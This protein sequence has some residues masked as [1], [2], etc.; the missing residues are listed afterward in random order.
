MKEVLRKGKAIKLV[1][2][3]VML[4]VGEVSSADNIR[5]L[6]NK[7]K[8]YFLAGDI[9]AWKEAVD[10]LR[11]APLNK[12]SER[13]LL[14]AEYGLIGNYIGAKRKSE[15]RVELPFFETRLEKALSRY[16][17]DGELYAFLAASV[18]Y[19]IALQPLS[20]PFLSSTHTNNIQKALEL[21]PDM[22]LPLV[23]QAN[24]L[25]FRPALVGGDKEKSIEVYEKAFNFY[26]N[27]KPG[28]WMYYNVGAWLGQVYANQGYEQKAEA[29]Y[30]YLLVTAP[31]FL[32]VKDEL[33]P[34]LQE[35]KAQGIRFFED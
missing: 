17:N 12:D 24:S 35:G 29:I 27:N 23:E 2:F 31:D 8:V 34:Q 32:W 30:E 15:A 10:S 25:Y 1:L 7:F 5:E 16:P 9:P 21:S 6:N 13:V 14:Y 4:I 18:A 22:G 28:H 26:H 3:I 33:L 19:N 11:N 20:A